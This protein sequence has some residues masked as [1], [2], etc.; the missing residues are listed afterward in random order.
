[1]DE[2]RMVRDAY[3]EP[4]PPTAR[5]IARARALLDDPPRRSLPRLRWRLACGVLATGTAAAVAV[6]F[7]GGNAPAPTGPITLDDRAAVLAAAEKAERQPVGSYWH[8]DVVSGQSYVVRSGTGTY[9][10]IGAHNESFSWHGARRGMGERY[11]GRDLPVRPWTARDEAVWRGS[12]APSG[13]RVWSGDKYLTLTAKTTKWS[14]SG[15]ERGTNPGGGGDFLGKSAEELRNLPTDPA[16]LT[17]LFLK[18]GGGGLNPDGTSPRDPSGR[19]PPGK[20][21]SGEKRAGGDQ[22]NR[23]SSLLLNSPM[24]PKV[25]AGL[26]RA[27]AAQPGIHAIGR[28]ADPLGR[29]GIALADDERATT[30]TGEWGGPKADRGTYRSREVVVFDERT[31]ALLSRQNVLTRPGG[32]YAQMKPGFIIEFQAVRSEGWSDTKP[33]PR[34]ELPYK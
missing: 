4:A 24:P 12:G 7:A 21:P 32:P 20:D 3:P 17:E 33:T 31:G 1:M 10:V 34:P 19:K 28:T 18:G 11:Y 14:S 13:I 27:L 25:R 9:A 2:V 26:M 16:K 15:P 29:R 5:E 8:S 23:V 22:I 30:V 6:T